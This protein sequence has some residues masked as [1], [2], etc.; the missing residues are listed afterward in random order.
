MA[1]NVRWQVGFRSLKGIDYTVNISEQGWTGGV[2]QLTPSDQPFTTQED[3]DDD[4]F[5]PIRAQSG[6]L[7]VIDATGNLLESLMPENNTQRLVQLMVGNAVRWQGFL[8]ADAYTQPWLEGKVEIEMPLKSVLGALEDVTIENISYER[9]Q[10]AD[11]FIEAFEALDV[12]PVNWYIMTDLAPMEFWFTLVNTGVFASEVEKCNEGTTETITQGDSYGDAI[13]K[14][15]SLFGLQLREFGTNIYVA[16]YDTLSYLAYAVYYVNNGELTLRSEGNLPVSE[17]LIEDEAIE[18]RGDDSETSFLQGARDF[19]V[20]L[21]LDNDDFTVIEMP[22]TD[23]D[24]SPTVT[25]P[26][27]DGG[28]VVV[29]PHALRT[30]GKETF[31]FYLFDLKW[32]L[33]SWYSIYGMEYTEIGNSTFAAFRRNTAFGSIEAG[34][35][36]RFAPEAVAQP[37]EGGLKIFEATGINTGAMPVRW[38]QQADGHTPTLQN[39]LWIVQQSAQEF[40]GQWH[41]PLYRIQADNVAMIGKYL[42]IMMNCYAFESLNAGGVSAVFNDITDHSMRFRLQWGD[43]YWN[44]EQW[45]DTSASFSIPFNHA[46]IQSNKEDFSDIDLSDGWIIPVPTDANF[47]GG[48]I[49]FSILASSTAPMDLWFE[50][51]MNRI[52]TNLKV[53]QVQSTS[54]TA[55]GRSSNT[56]R[57]NNS[58][59]GFRGEKKIDLEIGTINNNN[60]TYNFIETFNLRTGMY[61]YV[62]R[63]VYMQNASTQYNERPELHLLARLKKQYE[64]VRRTL[65]AVVQTGMN[66]FNCLYTYQGKTYY[67]IHQKTDWRDDTA[68]MKFIEVNQP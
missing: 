54:I 15:L 3:D 25:V 66:T 33:T 51:A 22:K 37:D 24:E 62:E 48:N 6:Y 18:F 10:I 61:E 17:D 26:V 36:P 14:I 8:Q 11:I 52:I 40:D 47:S 46:N 5:K 32:K 44:G 57:E 38:A 21:D 12:M 43:K 50:T 42:H 56:Y 23:E 64:K 9:K 60:G 28:D 19:T 2:T 27:T 13:G 41:N 59:R 68:S 4:V 1:W 20:E 16:Q 7:R 55:S 63:F 39:G 45:V 30:G 29:Q 31:A 34:G 49:Y 35:N 65:T 58:M 67:G 53:E